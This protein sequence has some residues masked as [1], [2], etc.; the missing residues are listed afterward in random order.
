MTDPITR[1]FRDDSGANTIEYSLLAALASVGGPLISAQN[2][3]TSAQLRS[4]LDPNRAALRVPSQS[5]DLS[6][7]WSLT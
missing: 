1:F 5:L 6:G 4:A 3:F 7:R 2:S